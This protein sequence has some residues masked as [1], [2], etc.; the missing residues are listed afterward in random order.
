MSNAEEITV[1]EKKLEQ[2]LQQ[3]L[4]LSMRSGWRFVKEMGLSMPQMFALHYLHYKGECNISEIA[5]ELGVSTAAASQMLERLVQQGLIVREENP[6]DRRNKR[7]M[8]SPT[9]KK[10]IRQSNGAYQTWV[11]VL[12]S[13]LS[14]EELNRLNYGLD[15]LDEHLR[16]L[17]NTL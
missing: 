5:H 16:V 14:P 6:K 4:H 3:L 11:H 1:L 7:I 13:R 15:V 2:T 10:V 12:F 8:L 17:L 9:G